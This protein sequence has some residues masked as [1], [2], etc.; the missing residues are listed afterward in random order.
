MNKRNIKV[1]V[2]YDGTR[3]FGWQIQPAVR[4]IQG[5]LEEKLSHLLGEDVRLAA[6]GRTDRGVHAKGQV[7]NFI[8][9][10][11]ISVD[12]LRVA[13]NK[14]LPEDIFIRE[15]DEVSP[16]FHARYSAIQRTYQYR[17][18]L[19]GEPRSPFTGRY[20]WYPEKDLDFRMIEHATRHLLGK[21]DFR[22]LAKRSGLKENT[23]CEV[24]EAIW[25]R[26][27]DGFALKVTANRFL[28]QMIRRIIAVLV[29]I[30]TIKRDTALLEDIL[31]GRKED[32]PQPW[33][34]PPQGL[35]LESVSY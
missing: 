12:N 10:S 31:S 9:G 21:R 13:L 3:Y 17:L 4:T 27:P 25:Q 24:K 23:W 8:S 11:G 16:D 15:I 35:F 18:G 14:R 19:W 22:A 29:D 7:A 1:V 5:I 2:A 32:W 28:P 33:V 30:G 34:A 6:A 26:I 20:C